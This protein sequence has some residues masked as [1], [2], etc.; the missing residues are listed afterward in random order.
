VQARAGNPL[1][2]KDKLPVKAQVAIDVLSVI[3]LCA[4]AVFIALQSP[5]SPLSIHYPGTESSLHLY[6]ATQL[7][8][9][10]M[11]YRDIFDYHGPL[12]PLI[13]TLGLFS[14][15]VISTVFNVSFSG[16]PGG[17]GL[18]VL[19][20]WVVEVVFLLTTFLTVFF[21][22]RRAVGSLASLL[23]GLILTALVGASIGGGNRIE[24]YALLFQALGLAGFVD[25]F[26]RRRLSILGVYLIGISIALLFFLK[27]LLA[28]FWLPFLLVLT[29][30][31][32]KR[33]SP[34]VALSRLLSI[35]FSASTVFIIVIPWL[36]V[37]NALASSIS[38]TDV[39]YRDILAL[40]SWQ[41][42]ADV[43]LHFIEQTP[44]VLIAAISL[45]ALIKLTVLR[46]T[47]K[48]AEKNGFSALATVPSEPVAA[49]GPPI[50]PPLSTYELPP[51]PRRVRRT[52]VFR[53]RVHH[54]RYARVRRVLPW[55]NEP[56]GDNT[57]TLIATNLATALIA[58]AL[59]TLSGRPD[60][61]LMLQGLICLV[62]PLAYLL[63]FF[64]HGILHKQ[65]PRIVLGAALIVLLAATVAVPGF[66]TTA[67][68]IE[69]Q[70][71]STPQLREQQELVRAV[72]AYRD[73]ESGGDEPLVVFGDECWVYLAVDS[74][75][76]TRYAYQPFST[77]FRPDLNADFYRQLGIADSYLLAGRVDDGLIER[78]PGISGYERVFENSRYVLYRKAEPDA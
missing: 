14:G 16:P 18:G 45:A 21:M 71:E 41:Q 52:R 37:T 40:I 26:L 2:N 8:D 27:P 47:K 3:L 63:H 17:T 51:P 34:G 74:Y 19:G 48:A 57:R 70:R 32:F 29:V 28:A 43:L 23:T 33:E 13:D 39:F 55:H 77:T 66:S 50:A 46:H 60:E 12:A 24:E 56:F 62:I 1:T 22:L 15:T 44:F 58:F 10:T 36:Y 75:S 65:T 53:R 69:Q 73:A 67:A 20:V 54:V 11:L 64:T 78:Y 31:L 9:G 25:Y 72:L 61:P 76:A 30:L 7:L 49:E 4:A 38:Q 59:M 68:A 5:L 6:I 35:I 42:R